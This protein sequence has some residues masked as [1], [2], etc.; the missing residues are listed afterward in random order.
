[1]Q[2]NIELESL[3]GLAALAIIF[4]HIPNFNEVLNITFFR[5]LYLMVDLFFVLSGFVIYS[6]YAEKLQ[7]KAD[8]LRFQFLRFGRLYPIHIIFLLVF[9]GFE[10]A[11]YLLNLTG[12]SFSQSPAFEKNDFT[13]FLE[14][15]FLIQS[16]TDD[17]RTF[18][19]V[20]WSISVEF[21]TYILFALIVFYLNK[22]KHVV[23]FAIALI[24]VILLFYGKTYGIPSVFRCLAGFFAGCLTAK[25]LRSQTS[26][27]LNLSIYLSTLLFISLVTFV[28]LTTQKQFNAVI[29]FITSM[30]IFS[31]VRFPE[32]Y[33]NYLLKNKVLVYLGTIS[34][35][36]YMS[37]VCVLFVSNYLVKIYRTPS[38]MSKDG[39]MIPYLNIFELSIYVIGNL[40]VI[41][42]L[43]HFLYAFIEKPCRERSR[44]IANKIKYFSSCEKIATS[45]K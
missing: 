35:S 9:L 20:A 45:I 16:F 31:L 1:M 28:S 17:S 22:F 2:K 33:L 18:N 38:F 4:T 10:V 15:L 43:S 11:R 44:L 6:A 14:Q 5:N 3:R 21:Y 27:N 37:H 8:L 7:T 39:N 32:G 23:F 13:A 26:T 36:M 40:I 25:L 42:L 41:F 30:L 12:H 24:S 29:Y 34:Y 19:F